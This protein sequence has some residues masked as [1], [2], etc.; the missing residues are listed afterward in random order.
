MESAFASLLE[1]SVAKIGN[2]IFCYIGSELLNNFK[3]AT[4]YMKFIAI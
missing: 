1:W 2:S 4:Y 3:T